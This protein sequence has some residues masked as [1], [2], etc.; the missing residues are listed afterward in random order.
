MRM[1]VEV[2]NVNEAFS[3]SGSVSVTNSVSEGLT[4]NLAQDNAGGSENLSRNTTSSMSQSGSIVPS[5]SKSW[6]DQKFEIW[7][8]LV[9]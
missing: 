9:E 3:T 7:F 8:F 4:G 6:T 1:L 2:L 5:Y